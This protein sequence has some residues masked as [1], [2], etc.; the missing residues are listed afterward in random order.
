MHKMHAPL[1]FCKA[2]GRLVSLISRKRCNSLVAQTATRRQGALAPGKETAW[3]NW[4][5]EQKSVIRKRLA[6]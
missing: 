6:N 5:K 4:F 1:I 3:N 2:N